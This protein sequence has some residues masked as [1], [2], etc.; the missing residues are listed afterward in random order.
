M[1]N[2]SASNRSAMIFSATDEGD[3]DTE[4]VILKIQID[5]EIYREAKKVL[6]SIGISV[7]KAAVLVL[8]EVVAR[9]GLPFPVSENELRELRNNQTERDI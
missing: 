4:P 6:D 1:P 5:A 9:R 8:K 7:E 3:T 2:I